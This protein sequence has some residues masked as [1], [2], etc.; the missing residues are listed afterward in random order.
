MI[1]VRR[2]FLFLLLA[3]LAVG[4]HAALMF[5]GAGALA[6]FELHTLEN[7][8]ATQVSAPR[9]DGQVVIVGFDQTFDPDNY[10]D[11][12][13]TQPALALM[14][15]ARGTRYDRAIHAHVL[16][17]LMEAGA[18]LVLFDFFFE[19]S[20]LTEEGDRLFAASIERHRERVVIGSYI[21]YELRD[22]QTTGSIREPEE[23]MPMDN[24]DEVLGFVNVWPDGH[25]AISRM[26][27]GENTLTLASPA[28]AGRGVLPD[29]F[30]LTARG[31]L[32]AGADLPRDNRARLINYA[33]GAGTFPTVSVHDLF[34][35]DQWAHRFGNGSY[36]RD[37]IIVVGPASEIHWKDAFRTPAG[38]MLG[39]EIQAN[40]LGNALH[41]SWLR[42][43]FP[44]PWALLWTAILCLACW[45]VFI[46]R[47]HTT[48][49]LASIL[50][51]AALVLGL[52]AAQWVAFGWF[53]LVLPGYSAAA[54]SA[55]AV[56]CISVDFVRAHRDRAR[57][58]N[59]F[60]AYLAPTVVNRLVESGEEPRLGGEQ[61]ALTGFFS[62]V[63]SFSTFS[64]TLSPD[65][66]VAL[67]N[68]YL[69]AMTTL[70]ESHEGTLDKYIG[71]A[72][73]AM[74]GAPVP[75]ADHAARACACALAMQARL[76]ELRRAWAAEPARW[77]SLV[78]SMRMRIGLNTGLAVV[79]NMG[80]AKRFSYTMMGDTV[81]L[82]A[83]CESGAKTAGVYILVT[84]ATVAAARAGQ[85]EN[86]GAG[87]GSGFVFRRLDRWRVK[88]RAA[89]VEMYELVCLASDRTPGIA[90]CLA[91]Y[92][93]GLAAYFARDWTVALQHFRRSAVNEPLQPGR[94]AGVEKNPSLVMQ[95]RCLEFMN[96]NLPEDWDGVYT[97]KEK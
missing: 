27:L 12:L 6:N 9:T 22:G 76:D 51:A 50:F 86:D 70:L 52:H 84:E 17:R 39:V 89:P 13:A 85:P 88:G 36:F 75:A 83:R 16:E 34:V 47:Q 25:G 38:S 67:M 64:E 96:T 20:G 1:K 3:L 66:L 49:A 79:G 62:D 7:S 31:A 68:E 72:I 8:Y 94:D 5:F 58:R 21:Q 24:P 80:S 29:I 19:G 65:Q 73:V 77:P 56:I 40:C 97:M 46:R 23:I 42:E 10:R 93:K 35:P 28:L 74:F 43:A 54:T 48:R 55:L 37:K 63:Q 41:R 26:V 2:P 45:L 82:A 71:D 59:L 4:S 95:A 92:G 15:S 53:H 91:D 69:G 90:A 57:I 32:K 11:L 33:G 30:S 60:G 61:V 44:G 14:A 78:G 81:N 87:E 18:R